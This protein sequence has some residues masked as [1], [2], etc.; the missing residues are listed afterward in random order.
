MMGD[1]RVDVQTALQ[2]AG[3]LVPGLE[4][5]T[6]VDSFQDQPFEDD[7]V[8]VDRCLVRG[9]TQQGNFAAMVHRAQ[10]VTECRRIA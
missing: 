9:D 8:S 10:Q 1:Y 5:L 7:L 6:P 2:H 4:H 3:H